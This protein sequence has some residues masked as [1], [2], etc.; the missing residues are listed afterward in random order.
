MCVGELGADVHESK[1]DVVCQSAHPG[2]CGEG[3]QSNH[4]RVLDQVL[5]FSSFRI[6]NITDSF[7]NLSF[8]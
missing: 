7:N 8:I 1:V 6:C 4:Q 2:C 5:T 3:N